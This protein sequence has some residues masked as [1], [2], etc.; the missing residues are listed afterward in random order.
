[1]IG[2]CGSSII[3]KSVFERVGEFNEKLS[4]GEDYEYW[5]RAVLLHDIELSFSPYV[6]F[7]YRIHGGQISKNIGRGVGRLNQAIVRSVQNEIL[8]GNT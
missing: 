7:Q 2:C 4:Y 1:M 8:N 5:L 6:G 3:H